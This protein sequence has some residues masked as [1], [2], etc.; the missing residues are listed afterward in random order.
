MK[1]AYDDNLQIK[2]V[3]E[4]NQ[5]F[6]IGRIAGVELQ[7]AYNQ[8]EGNA[9]EIPSNML[10]LEN[11]AGIK[12]ATYD[13]LSVYTE[14]LLQSYEHCTHIAEW[15]GKVFEI[16][17]KGQ[18]LVTKRT[19]HIP[20]LDAIALEPYY[21]QE[22]WMDALKGKRILIVHPFVT[23]IQQQIENLKEIFPNRKWFEGCTFSFVKPPLTL[24]GNH[25]DK[26]WQLHHN[27]CLETIKEHNEYDVA[28]VAAGGYGMLVADYIFT[29]QKKSVIYVG[30][31]LQLFFGIIGKRWFTNQPIMKLV[32]DY[33]IRPA[34]LDK[35]NDFVKV[36]KGCYW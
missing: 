1:K 16:T 35:P 5:P 32:N 36:E 17:G 22:S 11:N 19:P 8:L 13:S 31:A 20:K 4:S 21:F 33:W 30:G 6:F 9:Y 27:Q 14:K 2:R 26:D 25:Q 15:S 12:I 28:L 34:A 18:N 7:T 23:T 3:I 24:A 29:E 10:E